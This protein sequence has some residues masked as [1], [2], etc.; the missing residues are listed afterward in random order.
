MCRARAIGCFFA[1]A[2][3]LSPVPPRQIPGCRPWANCLRRTKT[4]HQVTGP[5]ERTVA[6][7]HPQFFERHHRSVMHMLMRHGIVRRERWVKDAHS[8]ERRTPP[9]RSPPR[10]ECRAAT[11][12]KQNATAESPG[13]VPCGRP[14][15]PSAGRQTAEGDAPPTRDEPPLVEAGHHTPVADSSTRSTMLWQA[16]CLGRN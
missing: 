14:A 6:Q 11:P 9:V 5:H 16:I 7:R 8:L 13:P 3:S 2:S 4:G 1:Y 10:R 15:G 12:A